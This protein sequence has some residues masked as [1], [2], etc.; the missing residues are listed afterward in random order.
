MMKTKKKPETMPAKTT[1]PAKKPS[2]SSVV[3][4]KNGTIFTA[5]DSYKADILIRG[6]KIVC[7]ADKIEADGAQV[8]DAADQE[9]YPGGVETHTHLE[10]PFMGTVSADDF[11]S[12]SRAAACGGTT[13][14]IDFV[15]P[16]KGQSLPDALTGWEKKAHGKTAIDYGF[17]IALVEFNDKIA[18]D[19]PKV[20]ARG[21]TSFKCFQAYKGVFMID[22]LQLLE[23]LHLT[24]KHGA[25]VSVHAENGDMLAYI[26]KNLLQEKKTE[27]RY[28]PVAHPASAEGEAVHRALVLARAA[29]APLYIVHMS[30]NEAL[31]EVKAARAR[32]QF[33]FAETCPQYLV[34][35]DSVYQKNGFEAAKWV[36]S[37]P[38]RD[39][40]H[41]E[42]F[43][44]GLR[45]GYIQTVGTDH[46]AF[47]FGSQKSMGKKNFT[48]IPNG[49]PAV[50]DR[51]NI[52]YSC[53]VQ[54][55]KITRNQFVAIMSTNPAKIFGLYPQKGAIA[56]G[57]DADIVIF[58]PRKKGKISAKTTHHNVDYSAFEGLELNGM[59]VLVLSRGQIIAK[60]DTF[61]GS[62]T[63]GKFLKRRKF[64]P[65][66][67]G[68]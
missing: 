19:I 57:S 36:M 21:I 4:I 8:I 1:R 66:E 23:I 61:V 63:H 42:R 14:L 34:L 50:G 33:V 62:K 31:E 48:Q 37:P 58:D 52:L 29:E 56:I 5:A 41:L 2:A 49:I 45:D 11:E 30:C 16:T 68:F 9:I 60:N 65:R 44:E 32:G 40:A 39:G 35:E 51:L 25:I 24:K 64:D 27:A 13:T 28:H 22:D 10:L 7:I 47:N 67:W 17:H 55:G 53:G 12:G 15:I 26:T 59:P 54:K 46:C 6:E 20:V 38:L 43:W 3:L 18:A